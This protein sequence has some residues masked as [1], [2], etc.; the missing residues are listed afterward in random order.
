MKRPLSPTQLM[1]NGSGG[2][3]GTTICLPFSIRGE[4]LQ[5]L[6]DGHSGHQG[7]LEGPQQKKR[8]LYSLCEVCNLQ[9]NSPAQAQVHYNG[10]SHLRRVKQLNTGEL[11]LNDSTGTSPAPADVVTCSNTAG[12]A[13]VGPESGPQTPAYLKKTVHKEKQCGL[14][15]PGANGWMGLELG[16]A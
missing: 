13:C 1:G 5:E 2:S 15:K 10:R 3:H 6:E 16:G 8:L 7:H 4:L 11:P 14:G 12:A 9:L